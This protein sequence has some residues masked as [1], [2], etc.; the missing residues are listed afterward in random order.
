MLGNY[1]VKNN[2]DEA[3]GEKIMLDALC[4]MTWL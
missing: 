2:L 3:A 4:W 1:E